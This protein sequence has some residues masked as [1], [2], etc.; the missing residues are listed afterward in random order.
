LNDAPSANN[1]QQTIFNKHNATQR[2]GAVFPATLLCLAIEHPTRTQTLI[3]RHS[4][5]LSTRTAG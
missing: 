1:K 2:A 5:D 3:M 4:D